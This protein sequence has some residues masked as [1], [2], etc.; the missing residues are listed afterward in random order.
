VTGSSGDQAQGQARKD[1][2]KLEH[3]AS[4]A[5]AKVPGA[6]LSGSGLAIFLLWLLE[7]NCLPR[8][9]PIRSCQ[10]SFSVVLQSLSRHYVDNR[11]NADQPTKGWSQGLL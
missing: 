10:G 7:S 11:K 5:T 2:A 4:H 9:I 6:T 3:D 8:T 1:Q